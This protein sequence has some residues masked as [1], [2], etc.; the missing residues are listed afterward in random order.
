MPTSLQTRLEAAI[1]AV[2][3]AALVTARVQSALDDVRAMTKDDA[4]PVTVADLASQAVVA[5]L[6]ADTLGEPLVLVGE[7]DSDFLRKPEHATHLEATLEAARV[8][9]P[10]LTTTEMLAAIDMGNG[11]PT[12]DG[13]WTLDPIDGTK[14]FLRGQ[15]YAIALAWIER[16]RPTLAVMGCPTSALRAACSTLP[17]PEQAAFSTR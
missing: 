8:A 7:E 6:L 4:S 14:G 17:I 3:R 2:R 12:P 5:S 11:K 9:L 1:E 10:E 15:Q 16:G 13:F